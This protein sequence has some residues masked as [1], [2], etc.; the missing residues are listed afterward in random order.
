MITKKLISLL[1]AAT[2]A[3]TS[4]SLSFVPVHAETQADAADA[5]ND[6]D[7]DIN[8]GG[9]LGDLMSD[10]FK[11][12]SNEQT[13]A[14]NSDYSIY[15][16]EYDAN[17]ENLIVD[18]T[19]KNDSTIFIGFFN[20]EG[21]QL[22]T[23][24]NVD[25]P[26]EKKTQVIAEK[27]EGLPEYYLIKAFMVSKFCEPL[28]ETCT[29]DKCTKAV[30]DIISKTADQF[31]DKKVLRFNE[32]D[33]NNFLVTKD[34]YEIINADGEKDVFKEQI[35]ESRFSF[36][37]IDK[38]KG[39]SE[40]QTVLIYTS[41]N[42]LLFIVDSIEINGSDAIIT[43]KSAKM[44]DIISLVRFD[45]SNY[46]GDLKVTYDKTD[47]DQF[48][49][50]E[51]LDLDDSDKENFHPQTAENGV[52][53]KPAPT[54]SSSMPK[55]SKK[56]VFDFGALSIDK[57]KGNTEGSISAGGF[58]EVGFEM[59][60]EVYYSNDTSSLRGT[61]REYIEAGFHE[62]ASVTK[63][64]G[65]IEVS[66]FPISFSITPQVHVTIEGKANFVFS[67]TYDMEI[68][69]YEI[70]CEPRGLETS[71]EG[72]AEIEVSVGLDI[73]INFISSLVL[74][75]GVE[76]EVGVKFAI[77]GTDDMNND[78]TRHNCVNCFS[79][80]G[81]TF[82]RLTFHLTICGIELLNDDRRIEAEKENDI[83]PFSWHISDG[84][85]YKGPCENLSHKVLLNVYEHDPESAFDST[86]P[87]FIPSD[88]AKIFIEL[89]GSLK[90][91]SDDGG[92][93]VVTDK[94]G[95]AAIWVKD[96]DLLD[97][98]TAI[99][100]QKKENQIGK[101]YTSKQWNP[102]FNGA[103][104][105]NIYITE[106]NTDTLHMGLPSDENCGAVKRIIQGKDGKEEYEYY[107]VKF[108]VSET[109]DC[110]VSGSGWCSMDR[111]I[112]KLKD[113]NID[114]LEKLSIWP[115]AHVRGK[116]GKYPVKYF[117]VYGGYDAALAQY[118]N[119]DTFPDSFF[120]N[121]PTLIEADIH[122]YKT[123]GDSA[124]K[125]CY[126]LE[127]VNAPDIVYIYSEAFKNSG[128]KSFDCPFSLKRIYTDAFYKCKNLTKVILNPGLE[129]IGFG[130]FDQTS[131]KSIILPDSLKSIG[132][133]A[134]AYCN[135]LETIEINTTDKCAYGPEV[136]SGCKNLK[137][138]I[139]ADTVKEI[140]YG[141][142]RECNIENIHLPKNLEKIGDFA[143]DGTTF[144]SLTLP[145]TVTEIG[146]RA[147]SF[148]NLSHLKLPSN[149]IK[150]GDYAFEES[151]LSV[152][153]LPHNLQS[154]GEMAFEGCANLRKVNIPDS[155]TQI[156]EYAFEN[157]GLTSINIP[158]GIK[159]IE[160]GVFK[161]TKIEDVTIPENV[162][163]INYDAFGNY[164]RGTNNLQKI[165]ILNS[166]CKIGTD[167]SGE[168]ERR[169]SMF[170]NGTVVYGYKNSTAQKYVEEINSNNLTETVDGVS[171]KIEL[172]FIALQNPT[173]TTTTTTAPVTTTTTQ[174]TAV[175]TN[176]IT[177]EIKCIMIAV[178]SIE[179]VGSTAAKLLAK[180]N[181]GFIDQKTSDKEGD[182]SF[183]YVPN[184]DEKWSFVFITEAVDN[185]ITE[186]YG[187]PDNWTTVTKDITLSDVKGDAN[188]DWD[189]DMSDIVLIMQAL[190]NP[191]KYGVN[192]TDPSH[193]TENGFKYADVDGGGLT[194]QDALKIQLYLLN[195]ISSLD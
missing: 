66:I 88:N 107:D 164:Y 22:Y 100:A 61:Y 175:I 176:K 29:Y 54:V 56:V 55:I 37:N 125:N 63:K 45:S 87:M 153:N 145:Y 192:G 137:N 11:E 156:E 119:D 6:S 103:A 35:D 89:G 129:E 90:P 115:G 68:E 44:E 2:T 33:N 78:Y 171:K 60:M 194:N 12:I 21:T 184:K 77:A 40:G 112:E 135:K 75:F 57:E 139:L 79:I 73:G 43:K 32:N 162:S 50:P 9:I 42:P 189:V 170:T 20:D 177:P 39:L 86:K 114:H 172:H 128:I 74:H 134:F 28:T 186:I 92:F 46:K 65:N 187:E 72:S 185:I 10:Q 155:V 167:L 127:K 190:A 47:E 166:N 38:I 5:S 84:V 180:D 1:V 111:L 71:F 82:F 181:V 163:E 19:A 117:E 101:V 158:K 59:D 182:V 131:I 165:T 80:T 138:V 178:K 159:T 179:T 188:G 121:N 133:I 25:A 4:L 151:K 118:E 132:N 53:R 91:C 70:K 120:E 85:L 76:P 195:K 141:E 34:E 108:T 58:I 51:I 122:G 140:S 98:S 15:K 48:E 123:I 143:F 97:D 136:F 23:S 93:R 104:T 95:K 147:F 193:I 149:L 96:S 168:L 116:I 16:I 8:T 124:F 105:L 83:E 94:D 130:A 160:A 17:M 150:I 174:V 26:A 14:H 99:V 41:K 64:I 27:P 69:D 7:T 102:Q 106:D 144:G 67:N 126:K 148:L 36:E 154:I 169:R 31:D 142:F 24:L 173:T 3:M 62:E 191:N 52:M 81:S 152:L 161:S 49:E 113:Y 183:S 110:I 13:E 109:G 30:Q 157:S 18:Y 146:N